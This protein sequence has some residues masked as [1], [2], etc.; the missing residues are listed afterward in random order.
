MPP[1]P[2][3][4]LKRDRPISAIYLGSNAA[5]SNSPHA[6]YLINTPPGLPDLPE[7]PSP[8]ASVSS[9]GSGLPSPPATNSTGS[10]S[11]G[12]PGSIAVRTRPIS[13]DSSEGSSGGSFYAVQNISTSSLNGTGHTRTLSRSS[14]AV[15]SRSNSR[16]GDYHDDMDDGDDAPGEDDTA[17]LNRQHV[18]SNGES[19]VISPPNAS[20]NVL[21]LQRVKNL[22]QRNRMALDKLSSISRLSTPSP[23][24]TSTIPNSRSPIPSSSSS[25]TSSSHSSHS[26]TSRLRAS[27]PPPSYE[28]GLSGSE[29][30]REGGLAYSRHQASASTS[31]LPSSSVLSTP[32]RRP[33]TPP[34][35]APSPISRDPSTSSSSTLTSSS[36]TLTSSSVASSSHHQARLRHTSAPGS[37]QKA[38]LNSNSSTG[39]NS[40]TSRRRKRA[41]V[42]SVLAD[43]TEEDD[44]GFA[45]ARERDRDTA[46]GGRGSGGRGSGS[47]G[48]GGQSRR[49]PAAIG[50][51]RGALPK[52]FIIGSSSQPNGNDEQVEKGSGRY[53]A[54]PMTPHRPPTT[55]HAPSTTSGALGRSS[56]VHDTR[57]TGTGRW[58]SG[59]YRSVTSSAHYPTEERRRKLSIETPRT[60]TRERRISNENR[61]RER[62]ISLEPPLASGTRERR[63]STRGGSAESALG[64]WSPTGR[65]LVG[66]GLRAAGLSRRSMGPDVGDA[67][68]GDVFRNEGRAPRVEW[69]VSDGRGKE[70]EDTMG[71]DRAPPRATTSMADYRYVDEY[72]ERDRGTG[73]DVDREPVL[74]GYKSAYPLP[75]R[76]REGEPERTRELTFPRREL[77][78]VRRER[79]VVD[80]DRAGSSM[81][82]YQPNTPA[83]AP[84]LQERERYSSPFGSRRFNT[85]PQPQPQPPPTP[86]GSQQHQPQTEHTRLMIESL[87]MFE[88]QLAKIPALA[89]LASSS[90]SSRGETTHDELARTAQSIVFATERLNSMLRTGTSRA[91]EAQIDAE[92]DDDGE[93]GGMNMV[94]VWRKVGGEYR[95]GL[96]TADDL[97]RGVTGFLLGVGRVM[98]E[99]GGS[100]SSIPN[101]SVAG[102]GGD[103]G[104]PAMHNRSISLS[105]VEDEVRR[106]TSSPDAAGSTSA[107]SGRRSVGSRR[108]WEPAVQEG[109]REDTLR[110]LAGDRPA[111]GLGSAMRSSPAYRPRELEDRLETPPASQTRSTANP[112]NQPA[113]MRRRLFTPREQREQREQQQQMNATADAVISLNSPESMRVQDYE[114]SPTPASRTRDVQLDRSRTLPPLGIPKPLPTLPSESR[115][116]RNV[117]TTDKTS[118][119]RERGTH[120]RRKASATSISTVRGSS[121]FPVL[122]TPV[123]ATTAITAHTVSNSPQQT[124]FPLLRSDSSKSTRSQVTFSRPSTVSVSALSGLQQQDQRQRTISGTSPV[125]AEPST[126]APVTAAMAGP[127]TP[128]SGS[129]TERDTRRRTIGTRASGRVSLDSQRSEEDG[130][131]SRA[132]EEGAEEDS[133]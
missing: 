71:R 5:F 130:G 117:T 15:L 64:I 55:T 62:R 32:S 74:R 102:S 45:T 10:G 80:R 41:S 129:E 125:S 97:V 93:T 53:S 85:Q 68:S 113:S 77:S 23:N 12:D 67:R 84:H 82:R 38:R 76:E 42:A 94:E 4:K 26:N 57:R 36:S 95:E 70:R 37:P 56:T 18:S 133:Y 79:D 96:R 31:H 17:R 33:N 81:S 30:E 25:H 16:A 89:S 8:G 88:S 109:G 58:V 101:G 121:A 126:S 2:V 115:L 91:L 63:Q 43:F 103:T 7:P 60:D 50:R 105:V 116:R 48:S 132:C 100:V 46:R 44:D 6:S 87:G 127:S 124:A 20:E 122:T 13:M 21:A 9:S 119:L 114:P 28:P 90:T 54:E 120:D 1:R 47:G 107:G 110:R 108:S 35:R 131:A 106:G 65:S 99:V 72:R 22:A 128:L 98:R 73:R 104:S 34:V 29:T 61:L 111:S 59:D 66:E 52:E 14:S 75:L 51:R 86:S 19:S 11:T 83:H 27:L 49:S 40:P 112:S 24:R 78:L 118:S 3:L 69:S 92:V 39:S 123:N